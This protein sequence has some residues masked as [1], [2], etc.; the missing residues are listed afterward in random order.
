MNAIFAWRHSGRYDFVGGYS[1]FGNSGRLDEVVMINCRDP[2]TGRIIVPRRL[3]GQWIAWNAEGDSVVASGVSL[4]EVIRAANQ[5]GVV[6][7]AFEKVPPANARLV[8]I[9]C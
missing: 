2:E 3:A 1:D 7:P 4:Q 8:G 5:A 6:D 9:V